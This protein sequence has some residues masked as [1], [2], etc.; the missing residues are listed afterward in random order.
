MLEIGNIVSTEDIVFCF[1]SGMKYIVIN[2]GIMGNLTGVLLCYLGAQAGH[3]FMHSTRVNRICIH[4]IVWGLICGSLG[5]ILSGGGHSDSWIPIN[6]NL[7]SLTFVLI[8][9]SLA[10]F[11]LTVLYLLVDVYQLFTGEP[12]LWL[13]MNSIVIYV[14]HGMFQGHFFVAFP[15]KDTHASQIAIN[16]YGSF[17]WSVVAGVM[18]WK[19]IFIAI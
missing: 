7:W 14:C 13:G 19:K 10:F 2:V 1:F 4:W 8:L 18:Y 12:F 16:L 3:I 6:K 11:N 5:L 15:A 17:F 9:S